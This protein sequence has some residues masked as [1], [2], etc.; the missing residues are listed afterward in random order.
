MEDVLYYLS[1]PVALLTAVIGTF[2]SA[3]GVFDPL[4]NTL[5]ATSGMWFPAT[6]AFARFVAP[7]VDWISS[8]AASQILLLAGGVFVLVSVDRMYDYLKERQS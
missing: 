1:H 4:L 5:A 7:G 3:L 6:T 8:E 2:A